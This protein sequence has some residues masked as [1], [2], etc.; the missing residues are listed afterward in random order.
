MMQNWMQ[1]QGYE[2]N[3]YFETKK[4]WEYRYYWL[5]ETPIIAFG[6][7]ARS[8]SKTI[9]F[10]KH[11]G[12]EVFS[13]LIDRNTLPIARYIPLSKVNQM[14]RTL[15]L[16]LQLKKGLSLSLFKERYSEDALIVFK[17]LISELKEFDCI[18]T[19]NNYISLTEVGAFFVEDV[20]DFIMDYTLSQESGNLKRDPHSL[21]S[22]AM[23]L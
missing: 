9:T 10:D 5:K 14:Y 20:C 6:S 11:E 7:R 3:G 23:R 15:F 1:E 21:G 19:D 16:S 22:K 18:K 12:I 17:Q 8:Y 13:K 2:Q 4:F